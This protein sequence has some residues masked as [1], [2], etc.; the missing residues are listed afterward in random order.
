MDVWEF[1]AANG[2][3]A[4]SAAEADEINKG[5]SELPASK[6]PISLMSRIEDYIVTALNLNSVRAPYDRALSDL[7][8]DI[9]KS[10]AVCPER[11][12]L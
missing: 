7:L 6:I 4:I 1:F 8:D 3:V 12:L 5:L 2:E 10:R 11:N 9:R